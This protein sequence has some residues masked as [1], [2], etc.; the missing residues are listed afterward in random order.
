MYV[1]AT[2]SE[3]KY[4]EY[5]KLA[6]H[7]FSIKNSILACTCKIINSGRKNVNIQVSLQ[8]NN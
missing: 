6:G 5:A 8:S 3:T 7:N 1:K 4:I 2:T